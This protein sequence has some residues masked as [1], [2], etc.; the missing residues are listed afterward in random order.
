MMVGS[1][2]E[3]SRGHGIEAIK[4]IIL[5]TLLLYVVA[6]LFSSIMVP[7]QLKFG[8]EKS[9]IALM[10]VFGIIFLG[11]MFLKTVLKGLAVDTEQLTLWFSQISPVTAFIALVLLAVVITAISHFISQSIMAKKSF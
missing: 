7:F 5:G 11:T 6:N 4:E 2:L 1:L 3:F 9:R 10:I 8:H